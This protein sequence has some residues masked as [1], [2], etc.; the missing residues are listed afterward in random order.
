MDFESFK[1]EITFP[2]YTA[3]LFCHLSQNHIPCYRSSDRSVESLAG[4]QSS[5][6]TVESSPWQ[7]KRRRA[8][9]FHE[10]ESRDEN[11]S[12]RWRKRRASFNESRFNT[13]TTVLEGINNK[14]IQ[15]SESSSYPLPPPCTCPYFGD[16]KTH[17]SPFQ[18]PAELKIL[19][20]DTIQVSTGKLTLEVDKPASPSIS[21][22]KSSLARTRGCSGSSSPSNV[23]VTWESRRSHRRGNNR[24]EFLN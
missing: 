14:S 8:S 16:S 10:G 20:S 9:T 13:K 19:P 7:S 17:K 4:S 1:R 15:P 18:T 3:I 22:I 24:D 2:P 11:P 5:L 6:L 12:P 23:M 21:P